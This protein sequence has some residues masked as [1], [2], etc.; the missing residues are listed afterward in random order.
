MSIAQV[1]VADLGWGAHLKAHEVFDAHLAGLYEAAPMLVWVRGVD[2]RRQLLDELLTGDRTAGELADACPGSR[3]SISKHLRLLK[4]ARL[5]SE[6]RE[7]R[8][9]IYTLEPEPMAEIDAWLQK[10]RV[11]WTAR[12]SRIKQ[13]VESESR[14]PSEAPRTARRRKET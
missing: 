9:R 4:E 6:R 13:Y 11:F 10:Y 7:G 1:F 2:L 8:H 5:V 14:A 12:L 3:P